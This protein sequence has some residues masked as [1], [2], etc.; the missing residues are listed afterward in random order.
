MS[1][2]LRT[3]SGGM[4]LSLP[5]GAGVEA[6]AVASPLRFSETPIVYGRHA[7]TLGEHT[8]AVLGEMLGLDAER[9]AGLRERGVV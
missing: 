3:R 6:P 4:K 9:I 1:R 5:H 8:D 2:R 7:P